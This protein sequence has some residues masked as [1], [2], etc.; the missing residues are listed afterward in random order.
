MPRK[1]ASIEDRF[2][3]IVQEMGVDKAKTAI[4][5][6]EKFIAKKP[7]GVLAEPSKQD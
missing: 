4:L 5:M 3:A 1:K 6:L 2:I 7:D